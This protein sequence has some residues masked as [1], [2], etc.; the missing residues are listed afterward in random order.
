MDTQDCVAALTDAG[1]DE[2]GGGN[3]YTM[4][5]KGQHAI[6]LHDQGDEWE[7]HPF[8]QGRAKALASGSGALSL[9]AFLR[10]SQGGAA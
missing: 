7:A 9:T 1:Y 3:G 6:Y 8:G 4:F 5:A 10:E 2:A